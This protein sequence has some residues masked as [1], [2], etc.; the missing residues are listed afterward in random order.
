[1][2]FGC[3]PIL[4]IDVYVSIKTTDCDDDDHN[5]DDD[6]DDDVDDDDSLNL[7]M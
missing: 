7:F 3:T 4:S 1:M 2:Y 6:D 5:D